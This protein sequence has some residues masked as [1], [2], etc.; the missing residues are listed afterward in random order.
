MTCMN[1]YLLINLII[2]F[3]AWP[4]TGQ[5]LPVQ[6]VRT[7]SAQGKAADRIAAVQADNAGNVYIA[8][9]AGA[10]HG[11]PDAF[12]MK[13]NAQGDTLWTY[14]YDGGGNR[15]DYAVA[16][17]L[18]AQGN[19]YFTGHSQGASYFYDCITAKLGPN[20]TQAWVSR[21]AAG[22]NGECYGKDLAVDASGNVYVAGYVDPAAASNDWLVIK[23]NAQGQQQW[24][25]VHNGPGNGGD[26]AMAVAIAPNG[27]PTVCGF[28][29]NTS[30]NGGINMYIK[31]Y[32]PANGTVW[33]DTWTNPAFTGTD[34]ARNLGFLSNGDLLVGGETKNS[35]GSN[36]DAFAA[37][38]NAAGVR[39]WVTIYSDAT[40]TMDEYFLDVHISQAGDVYF[41][42]SDWLDGFVTCIRGDG[43][44]GWRKKW[45]GVLSNGFD[46][47][48]AVTTDE[49][50]NAY[51]T[52][53]GVYPGGNYY[54]NGGLPNIIISKYSVNGDSL[55]SYRCQDS[56]HSSMG[57]A[58]T[59]NQGK[60]YAG[61]FG[62]DTTWVNE[63]MYT[64]IL[65]TS[66]NALA[67]WRYNGKG[68]AI[69]RGQIVQAD[70]LHNVYVGA[71]VDRL[72]SEGTDIVLIKYDHAGNLLWESY[73]SSEGFHNDTLTGMLL[74][75]Q[76][77]LILS[78]SSDVDK[79]KSNYRLSLV[80]A[81]QHGNF[82][83]QQW[84]P[85]AGSRIT[86]AMA[87]GN[88][89]N[90]AM[91][92][93]SNLQGGMLLYIDSSL[94]LMWET[95]V[96]S[97]QYMVTRANSIA[98]FPGGDIALGGYSQL[99]GVT[100]GRIQR[101]TP[102]GSRQWD[103]P[104][105]SLNTIDEI[106]DVSI[107][108][109]GELAFTG[110]TGSV[111]V[112]GTL[113]GA[114]GNIIWKQIY[115]PTASTSEYGVKVRYTPAGNLALLC[116]GWTG[117]VARYYVAQY[118][119]T[120]VFQWGNVY[121]QTA[122][123]REPIAMLVEPSNRIVTA[124][125]AI[126]ATTTNYD[127]I[128]AGYNANGSVAFNNTY[129][130]TSTTSS[131]WDQLRSLT[132]D[133]YGNFIVSGQTATEFYNDWLFKTL[134]I[135]YGDVYVGLEPDESIPTSNLLVYPNPSPDGLFQILDASPYSISTIFVHDLS[136]RRIRLP[137]PSNQIIDL[138]NTPSGIYIISILRQN[139]TMERIKL[140]VF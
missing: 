80:K 118:S 37:R 12:V 40:T 7:F 111:V 49:N 4:G 35:T 105:D 85:A 16:L 109:A 70:S 17:A 1:R 38:Y 50:G 48:M 103:T 86:Q 99:S 42:G 41:A 87:L 68:D 71:T 75:H 18:D 115:N 107:S 57:M 31:Q 90:I 66:G 100:A 110:R 69:T 94:N 140:M 52:G 104:I 11:S 106:R 135:K 54:G 36:Q 136:G 108:P 76:G 53:R 121:N 47:L 59:Y 127:Y 30:P 62:T 29:Q 78:I 88:N 137:A 26:E 73:F 13:R 27:N 24:V 98:F 65:D 131:S 74:D 8:G 55:W 132:R 113:N 77:N 101:Y 83:S 10:H 126:N 89:G 123:D 45:K 93:H 79:L 112:L 120:G 61:G 2:L 133:A 43:N 92:V 125:W 91:A 130:S 23:Y 81:D 60:I 51:A 25:D 72:H 46:V 14:Y 6:W 124:G 116:R 119:G 134:T 138:R 3:I 9:Y 58:I 21:Y 34:M 15:E 67:E 114:N 82:S 22:S 117:F 139:G 97:T 128:L 19:I 96:D 28:I 5:Q 56:L 32:T 95:M 39:Q 20:G 63:D 44:M 129:N 102:A 33:T 122:S 64:I 84:F